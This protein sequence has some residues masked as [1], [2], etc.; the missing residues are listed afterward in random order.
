[1]AARIAKAGGAWDFVLIDTP[2]TLGLL[3]LNALAASDEILVPVTC[4][5]LTLY[6]LRQILE[7]VSAVRERV[8]DRIRLAGIVACRFDGRTLHS[9]DV[10]ADLQKHYPGDVLQT[11]IRE[12]VRLAEAPS[13]TAPIAVYAPESAGAQDFHALALEIDAR[14]PH[15]AKG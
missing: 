14:N 1:L 4:H 12:N 3:T 9:R 13:H 11:V 8:N 6:G 10:L 5:I 15:K 2:P 7:T